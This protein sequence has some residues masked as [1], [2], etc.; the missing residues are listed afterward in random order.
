MPDCKEYEEIL[1]MINEAKTDLNKNEYCISWNL[2][3]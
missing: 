2:K 3:P 1:G